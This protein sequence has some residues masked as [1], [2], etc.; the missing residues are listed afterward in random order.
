VQFF[1][2][3]PRYLGAA[4]VS[5]IFL[6]NIFYSDPLWTSVYEIL[7]VTLAWRVSVFTRQVL[8]LVVLP[9]GLIS[10]Q[11]ELSAYV[12][13]GFT[14][15]VLLFGKPFFKDIC[16]QIAYH[17]WYRKNFPKP[18]ASRNKLKNFLKHVF[19]SSAIQ[20]PTYFLFFFAYAFLV[21]N[22]LE[23]GGAPAH[24]FDERVDGLLLILFSLVTVVAF[25]TTFRALAFLGEGWRYIS[26]S[27]MLVTPLV[28]SAGA[29]QLTLAG[30]LIVV[31]LVFLSVLNAKMQFGSGLERSD[32]V[33]DLLFCVSKIESIDLSR[34]VWFGIP[35]SAPVALVIRGLGQATFA[36]QIGNQDQEI[37][38]TY[39]TRYP[40]LRWDESRN[41][42]NGVSHVLVDK[43]LSQEG[44]E[45]G[46]G[47]G[48]IPTGRIRLLVE[49]RRYQVYEVLNQ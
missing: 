41:V 21:A 27:A 11:P 39:F 20:L 7:A 36:F 44:A 29:V 10:Q 49:S 31:F 45:D 32:D 5:S 25:G 30:V 38:R 16:N 13:I 12:L 37:M 1:G 4:L 42:E 24:L 23:L 8:V 46:H 40:F 26:F 17:D 28:L 9:F 6:I 2:L 15:N 3:Q 43:V 34:V 33:T 22:R 14:I 19:F 35:Y 47:L 18:G 48:A